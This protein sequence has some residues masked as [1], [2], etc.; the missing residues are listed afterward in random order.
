MAYSLAELAALFSLELKGD[1]GIQIKAI[2]SVPNASEGDLSFIAESS[3][4]S[5]LTNCKA[6]A[7]VISAKHSEAWNG[8]ALISANPHADA[9]RIAKL[10]D[11]IRKP[12]PGIH[13]TAV[14]DENAT[15]GADITIGPKAIVSSGANIG[16]GVVVGPGCYVGQDVVIGEDSWLT[17]NVTL[18]DRIRIGARAHIQPGAVIGGRGFGLAQEEGAWVEVPQLGSVIIGNDVEIGANTCVDRGALGDTVIEEGVK[19]DNLVQVGHNTHIGAH[20]AIAGCVGIAG[21]CKIGARCQIGGAAGILGH[22]HIVDNVIITAFS[23]VSTS[24]EE[25]GLYS[26]SLPVAPAREWRRQV[27]R[28][29]NIDDLSKRVKKLEKGLE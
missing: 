22:L 11:P 6:S 24:I 27:A 12:Q 1:G 21:S 28:L 3:Y 15:L 25:P 5:Q 13:P 17:A 10:F 29:R 9:A 2:A 16:S 23:L 19:I 7:L 20:T 14:V 26:A 8:A 18:F 4:L